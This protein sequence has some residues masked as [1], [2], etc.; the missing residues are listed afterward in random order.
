M[1]P[2]SNRFVEKLR[3]IGSYKLP[4]NDELKNHRASSI[5]S[6]SVFHIVFGSALVQQNERVEVRVSSVG[7]RSFDDKTLIQFFQP[8]LSSR[9]RRA[10]IF[11]RFLKGLDP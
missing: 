3:Q 1:V 10:Q 11:T 2:T 7:T 6:F 9:P 5:I 4:I 8:M